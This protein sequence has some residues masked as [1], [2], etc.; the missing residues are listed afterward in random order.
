MAVKLA[1]DDAF[2]RPDAV[3]ELVDVHPGIDAHILHHMQ[4][5]FGGGHAG[6]PPVAAVGAAAEPADGAVQFQRVVRPQGAEGGVGRGDGHI[7]PVVQMQA[8]VVD[9]RPLFLDAVEAFLHFGRGAV[10]HR[11]AHRDAADVDAHLVPQIVLLF[12]HSHQAVHRELAQEVAAPTGVGAD[13]GLFDVEFLGLGHPLGPGFHFLHLAAVGV[14]A[15]EHIAH[16]AAEAGVG[17]ALDGEGRRVGFGPFH[18]ARVQRQGGVGY[19][20]LG[21]EAGDDFVDARHLRRPLGADERADDDVAQAGFRELIQQLDLV[22]DRDV[23]VLDL[24]PL[25]HPFFFVN[26]L[27]IVRH[28]GASF[29][30][31]AGP[32]GAD[33]RWRSGAN[34]AINELP[35]IAG[36]FRI[37][38]GGCQ[39]CRPAGDCRKAM[40]E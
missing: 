24:H 23:G 14:A 37:A 4:Q 34:G 28:P 32:A 36:N 30:A 16:M 33:M 17:V 5:V 12:Q 10:A 25:A 2:R 7:A 35:G 21:G 13:A 9:F 40:P 18:A 11:V 22:L 3:D 8:E 1:A 19:A 20:G 31:G 39:C 38:A 26:Y 27:R 15:H 6:G 29:Q